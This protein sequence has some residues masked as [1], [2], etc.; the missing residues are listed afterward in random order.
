VTAGIFWHHKPDEYCDVQ[1]HKHTGELKS[2]ETLRLEFLAE[3][4]AL[5]NDGLLSEAIL[6]NVPPCAT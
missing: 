5:M 4:K 3:L 1:E 6:N 2:S